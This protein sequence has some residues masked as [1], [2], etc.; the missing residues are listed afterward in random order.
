MMDTQQKTVLKAAFRYRTKTE[1]AQPKRREKMSKYY[2]NEF[3]QKIVEL[4][5]R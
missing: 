3:K 2:T 1:E 4:R 5:R